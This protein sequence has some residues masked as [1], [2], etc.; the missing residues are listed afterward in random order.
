MT[1]E[2]QQLADY[3]QHYGDDILRLCYTYVHNWQTAEDLTQDTFIK[4]YKYAHSYRGEATMK[5]YIYRIA[6]NVCNSYVQS[7]KFK[8]TVVTNSFQKL[9]TAKQ[10]V[11]RTIVARNEAEILVQAIEQLSPKYKD[12]LLLYYYADMPIQQVSE[13]LELPVNTVKTRLSRARQA[14]K[15]QLL[16][17]GNDYAFD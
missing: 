3:M 11:E 4:V 17:G 1:I 16:K 8:K 13:A 14:L 2:E 7:W 12:V 5:T 15:E 9:L 6:I 10:S